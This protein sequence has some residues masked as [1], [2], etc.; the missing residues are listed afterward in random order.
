MVEMEWRLS[1]RNLGV[2]WASSSP[3]HRR[4]RGNGIG[5]GLWRPD[6]KSFAPPIGANDF[7]DFYVGGL[8]EVAP[9]NIDHD[10]EASLTIG[11]VAVNRDP[12]QLQGLQL[13]QGFRGDFSELQKLHSTEAIDLP[14]PVAD[15]ADGDIHAI[16][17]AFVVGGGAVRVENGI[18]KNLANSI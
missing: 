18:E 1:T 3:Q 13:G 12:C 2:I 8:I 4:E 14:A 16:N 7:N 6:R 5:R 9:A 10:F 15:C 11:A 17:Y